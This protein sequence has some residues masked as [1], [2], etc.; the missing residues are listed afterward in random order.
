MAL[1]LNIVRRISPDFSSTGTDQ[2][3][4]QATW[5]VEVNDYIPGGQV[6]FLAQHN[7]GVNAVPKQGDTLQWVSNSGMATYVDSGAFALDFSVTLAEQPEDFPELWKIVV[8]WRAPTP[9]KDEQPGSAGLPPTSRP[10]EFSINYH[11][12]SQEI[13]E[14]WNVIPIGRGQF[15]TRPQFTKAP[16][17]TAAAERV[18]G[19]YKDRLKAVIVA[20]RNVISPAVALKLNNTFEDTINDSTW[21]TPY[22]Q[23]ARHHA[24][25]LRAETGDQIREGAFVF[26]RMRVSVEI[27]STPF[28]INLPNVGTQILTGDVIKKTRDDD[29]VLVEVFLEEDGTLRQDDP[30]TIPYVVHQ[31]KGY[32]SLPF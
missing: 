21:S 5:L 28:Y 17:A 18:H 23:V 2:P 11:T 8:T 14:A 1:I 30:I 24:R 22:I 7:G 26:W 13:T 9:G 4:Y 29:G 12:T 32:G 16:I 31:E 25:F 6:L 10:P 20:Q 19:F 3:R 15:Y 27:G